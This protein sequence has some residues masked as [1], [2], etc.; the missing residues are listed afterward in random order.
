MTLRQAAALPSLRSSLTR[1]CHARSGA[2]GAS[3]P[4]RSRNSSERVLRVA[5]AS[6]RALVE[7][8]SFCSH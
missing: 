3:N 7:S 2:R 8:R 5:V 6:C 4:T 1:A